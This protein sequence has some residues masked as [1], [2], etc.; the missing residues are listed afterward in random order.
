MKDLLEIIA[1]RL[2]D[3]PEG[4]SVVEKEGQRGTVLE[5]RVSPDDIGKVIGKQGKIA[6]AI[7]SVIRAAA[8]HN[9]EFV[10]VDIVPNN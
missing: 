4:V 7:R 6:K 1:K 3:D 9:K 8:I 10:S 2:V 5:L